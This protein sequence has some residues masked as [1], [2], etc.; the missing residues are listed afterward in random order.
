MIGVVPR[1][2]PNFLSS[3][4]PQKTTPSTTFSGGLFFAFNNYTECK[5]LYP[6]NSTR[7]NELNA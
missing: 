1:I 3:I 7:R 5:I 4:Q 6:M 2:I